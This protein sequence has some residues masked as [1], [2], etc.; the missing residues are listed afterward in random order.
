MQKWILIEDMRAKVWVELQ[1]G[2]R[3]TVNVKLGSQ[4]NNNQTKK[5]CCCS[6]WMAMRNFLTAVYFVPVI[7]HWNVQ[8]KSW[9]EMEERLRWMT[10]ERSSVSLFSLIP[11]AKA[12]PVNSLVTG[13]QKVNKIMESICFYITRKRECKQKALPFVWRRG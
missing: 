1:V 10:L 13:Y 2:N 8:P 12:P 4:K 6:H 3:W 9:K 5:R 7:L 11:A